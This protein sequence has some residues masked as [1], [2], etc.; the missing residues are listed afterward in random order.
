M[1][2]RKLG[3]GNPLPFN[4]SKSVAGSCAMFIFSLL[5]S[6]GTLALY[7]HAGAFPLDW[8][9]AAPALLLICAAATAVEAAPLSHIVDDNV[10]VPSVAMIMAVLLF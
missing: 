9:R 7:A 6:C 1:V 10:S 5:F 4:P 3:A 8:Q 2:G